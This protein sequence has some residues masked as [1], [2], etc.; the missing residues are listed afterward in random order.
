ML[1]VVDI[2][3]DGEFIVMEEKSF[4]YLLVRLGR[5]FRKWRGQVGR[6]KNLTKKR[7]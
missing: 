7:S 4:K 6:R 3:E 1:S 5:W 2:T